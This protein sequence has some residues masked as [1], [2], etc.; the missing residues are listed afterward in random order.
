MNT[1]DNFR[2]L[3]EPKE[4]NCDKRIE[5]I[6]HFIEIMSDIDN[7]ELETDDFTWI[8]ELIGSTNPIIIRDFFSFK[9]S[10]GNTVVHELFDNLEF[11]STINSYSSNIDFFIEGKLKLTPLEM[12]ITSVDP[13]AVEMLINMGA[14]TL[15]LRNKELLLNVS[16]DGREFSDLASEANLK[17]DALIR[18]RIRDIIKIFEKN[19]EAI[20][21]R[22]KQ[23][24][25]TL[26]VCLSF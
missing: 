26:E 11:L 23:E 12:A 8:D 14:P 25:N 2:T 10:N 9:A 6:S 16:F 18:E 22:I 17:L 21:E 13:D 4:Q 1:F 5:K 15:S 20:P 3:L 19:G 7:E 24:V